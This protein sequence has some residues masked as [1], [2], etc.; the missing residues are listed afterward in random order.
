M[1]IVSL[2]PSATEIVCAVGARSQLVGVSHECDW[3]EDVRQLPVV[4]RSRDLGDSSAAIDASVRESMQRQA[5]SIYQ[6]IPQTL[7][8]LAPDI[9]ITQDLCQVCA[10]PAAQVEQALTEITDNHAQLLRLSPRSLGDVLGDIE[11]VA[12]AAGRATDGAKAREA[13]SAR[14][15]HLVL[16]N[17]S[18]PMQV[19]SV[20][21][22]EPLMLGGLWTPEII[23][24]AGGSSLIANA[25]ELAPEVSSE[26]L[27]RVRPDL[28]LVK[29]CG[30]RLKDSRRELSLIEKLLHDDWPATVNNRVFVVDGNRYFNRSGPSLVDSAELLSGLIHDRID[31]NWLTRFG[32]HVAMYRR[33]SHGPRLQGLVSA[34]LGRG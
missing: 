18:A 2:L 8:A 28:V 33:D 10:V 22:L 26:Q 20:E 5:L 9:V 34:E 7:A 16:E 11:R 29:P 17:R 3:P 31:Q 23:D 13:L 27:R 24:L 12:V 25:G 32:E 6:V 21:W 1:R 14:L 15:R 4:T 30:F 19:L